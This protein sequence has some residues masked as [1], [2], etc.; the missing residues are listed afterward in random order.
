MSLLRMKDMYCKIHFVYLCEEFSDVVPSER[1]W[2][3][4]QAA[5]PSARFADSAIFFFQQPRKP[6]PLVSSHLATFQMSQLNTTLANEKIE[7]SNKERR[8]PKS[9]QEPTS[10]QKKLNLL[11][12]P[13]EIL[14]LI[15]DLIF[16]APLEIV[17]SSKLPTKSK[18]L[19][20]L[21]FALGSKACF[22]LA[23][24]FLYRHVDLRSVFATR[25]RNDLQLFMERSL[26]LLIDEFS[27]VRELALPETFTRHDVDLLVESCSSLEKL[28]LTFKSGQTLASV[29][30]GLSKVAPKTLKYLDVDLGGITAV[31]SLGKATRVTLP[32]SVREIRFFEGWDLDDATPL[33]DMLERSTSL[34]II[35]FLGGPRFGRGMLDEGKYPISTPKIK[36]LTVSPSHFNALVPH[37]TYVTDLF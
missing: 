35:Q 11:G 37:L 32:T 29:L 9:D 4:G 27:F 22:A 1:P 14:L 26:D 31:A 18:A 5:T 12:L 23:A 33:L 25:T 19:R 24:S 13:A 36:S 2:H 10:A 34:E 30:R 15:L 20:L 7:L 6:S 21:P 16:S 17:N 3:A 8:T 28:S